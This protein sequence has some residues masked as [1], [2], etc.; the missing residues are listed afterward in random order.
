MKKFGFLNIAVDEQEVDIY[1]QGEL[2]SDDLKALYEYFGISLQ[3]TT[4]SE[5]K[6]VLND[7]KDKNL[8]VHID[9][10]GG[11][12]FVGVAMYN[13]LME[14]KGNTT[15]V[16]DGI[17]ASAATLPMVACNKVKMHACSTIMIHCA[18]M[19]WTGGNANE[20]MRDVEKLR[21]LDDTIANA[22]EIKTN[23]KHDKILK[24]MANETWM[25]CREA[26]SKGFA[27]EIDSRLVLSDDVI[28]NTLAVHKSIYASARRP[29]VVVT[30]PI[31]EII[32]KT[33]NLKREPMMD[34]TT[35]AFEFIQAKLKN[36]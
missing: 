14:H 28:S 15:A 2:I 22:Y 27:D 30:K 33:K 20:L 12:Y 26:K 23:L 17:A 13:A 9:S 35:I 1:I 24:L 3:G 4:P 34:N 25:D 7:N 32:D 11:D 31:D 18:S 16:I 21:V 6:Q 8:T 5:F 29:K 36:M 19:G 10:I